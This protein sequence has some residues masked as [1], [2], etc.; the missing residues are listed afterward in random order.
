MYFEKFE[1]AFIFKALKRVWIQFSKVK[2]FEGLEQPRAK[3]QG[4]VTSQQSTSEAQKSLSLLPYRSKK[5]AYVVNYSYN[6]AQVPMNDFWRCWP[7]IGRSSHRNALAVLFT[8]STCMIVR[9]DQVFRNDRRRVYVQDWLRILLDSLKNTKYFREFCNL[10]AFSRLS[11]GFE[12][13]FLK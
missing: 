5:N 3:H 10:S 12:F 7:L 9:I 1:F 13:N 4:N 11:K 6:F 8:T 2:A